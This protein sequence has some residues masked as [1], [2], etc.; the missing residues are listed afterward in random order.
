MHRYDFMIILKLQQNYIQLQLYYLYKICL[1]TKS[2][3]FKRLRTSTHYLIERV[4]R[5]V[6]YTYDIFNWGIVIK[7]LYIERIPHKTPALRD[8][9]YK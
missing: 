4:Y 3:I 7:N 2:R 9:L 6:A 8:N 1:K 5:A